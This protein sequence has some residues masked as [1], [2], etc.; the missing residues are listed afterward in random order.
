M[1]SR[2]PNKY[3][4]FCDICGK[5]IVKY[6]QDLDDTVVVRIRGIEKHICDDCS[7]KIAKQRISR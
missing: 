4:V 6:S 3:G 5:I 2:K 7:Y 1:I